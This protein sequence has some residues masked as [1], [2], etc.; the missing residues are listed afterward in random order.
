[1]A[2]SLSGESHID[3]SNPWT[4]TRNSGGH[5]DAI[6]RIAT[7]YGNVKLLPDNDVRISHV[8]IIGID[9]KIDK[10]QKF[11]PQLCVRPFRIRTVI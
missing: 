10:S 9:F 5:L 2:T 6:L 11:I 8:R 3:V 7:D 4:S 1:M